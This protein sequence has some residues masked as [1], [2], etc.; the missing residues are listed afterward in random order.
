MTALRCSEPLLKTA[1]A[2]FEM[3]GRCPFQLRSASYDAVLGIF[4]LLDSS[5]S[6][7]GPKTVEFDS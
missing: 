6:H 7:L 3:L 1:P 4:E 2:Y 5:H